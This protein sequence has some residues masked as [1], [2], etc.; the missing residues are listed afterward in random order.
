MPSAAA[1]AD[2]ERRLGLSET[3]LTASRVVSGGFVAPRRKNRATA[4]ATTEVGLTLVADH[5]FVDPVN[6]LP[7]VT[8]T[9][10]FLA[11]CEHHG[12]ERL[13]VRL[14]AIGRGTGVPGLP[15]SDDWATWSVAQM[16]SA[17]DYLERMRFPKASSDLSATKSPR[18]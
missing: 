6:E 14:V 9:G 12:S 3:P 8:L 1:C 4:C 7:S 10:R 5:G 18:D 17:V 15:A 2:T 13:A 11:A 16:R